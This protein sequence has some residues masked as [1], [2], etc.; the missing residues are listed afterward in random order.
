M[1]CLLLLVIFLGS[2]TYEVQHSWEG[3]PLEVTV[4]VDVAHEITADIS[5]DLAHEVSGK[6]IGLAVEMK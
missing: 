3:E 1:R 4:H 2:C 6:A 5:A